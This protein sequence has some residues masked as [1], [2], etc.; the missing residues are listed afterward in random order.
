V[1]PWYRTFF[2]PEYWRLARYEYTAERTATELAYLDTV[3]GPAGG[4]RLVDIGCGL[5]RHAIPFAKAGFDV[6]G[7][8]VSAWALREAA[9]RAAREGV[10][11]Q[12]V[13]AD[14]LD[15]RWPAPRAEVVLCV[16]SFGW[17]DDA[18]QL[19]LL[20]RVRRGLAPGGLLV[21][22][23]SNA[24]W[25]LRHFVADAETM[26]GGWTYTFH[27]RF[28]PLTS[29]N[30]GSIT[31]RSPASKLQVL[32]HD[33]RLYTPAEV[34]TLV[35]TAGFDV[36]RIDGDFVAERRVDIDTRYAQVIAF[37]RGMPPKTLSIAARG[38]RWGDEL[39]LRWAPEEDEWVDVDRQALISGDPGARWATARSYCLEDPFGGIRAAGVIAARF[40][41]DVRAE[42]IAFGAGVSTLLYALAVWAARGR[43]AC[44]ASGYPD[45]PAWAKTHGAAID[46]LPDDADVDDWCAAIRKRRP[47]VV[48]LD[49]PTLDG[50]LLACEGLRTLAREAQRVGAAVIVDEASAN[51]LGPGASSIAETRR[52]DN[53]VVLRSLSKAYGAGG[54]R[55]GFAIA[56]AGSAAIVRE[57]VPPLQ[58]SSLALETALRLLALDDPF[59]RLRARVAEHKSEVVRRLAAAGVIAKAGHAALP[60]V[61]VRDGDRDAAGKLR[62][63]RVL[64]KHVITCG[65][66][67]IIRISV[68]LSDER[69]RALRERLDHRL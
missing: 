37:A 16:Q 48:L 25:I 59:V 2:S 61:I 31:I 8:D 53:L 23:F 20:R 38:E 65:T 69:M 66:A 60:W 54:L 11:L 44:A 14:A 47:T 49:R 67:P 39:D 21:L 35:E 68:P 41:C 52:V 24:L 6:V 12:L 28:D 26:I 55:I 46:V 33:I 9:A 57:M 1:Q 45:L 40:G 5:G 34:R 4:R 27:R 43:V 13:E 10:D 22:D 18:A 51:Y 64:G 29:R 42:H 7:I 32:E 63:R 50:E 30:V 19:Q 3:V 15:A 62:E 17:G 56:S 58:C 36:Q